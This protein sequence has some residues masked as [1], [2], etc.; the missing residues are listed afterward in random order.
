MK[1]KNLSVFIFMLISLTYALELQVQAQTSRTCCTGSC[2]RRCVK[3]SK[4]L[5]KC[6]K[7]C[8]SKLSRKRITS[9]SKRLRRYVRRNHRRGRNFRS[10]RNS[11]RVVRRFRRH[12][13]RR[14]IRRNP[15][16]RRW[17]RYNKRALRRYSRRINRRQI[18]R[19]LTLRKF[20]RRRQ[21]YLTTYYWPH[22][23]NYY[24]SIQYYPYYH[25][26]WFFYGHYQV[27]Y[28]FY[29]SYFFNYHPTLYYYHGSNLVYLTHGHPIVL[30]KTVLPTII[31]KQQYNVL[32]CAK[33]P[34]FLVKINY[35]GKTFRVFLGDVNDF[36]NLGC[37]YFMDSIVSVGKTNYVNRV[38]KLYNTQK[39]TLKVK[40]KKIIVSPFSKNPFTPSKTSVKRVNKNSSV[41][42]FT[43]N[44]KN[45][46]QNYKKSLLFYHLFNN[47]VHQGKDAKKILK[48]LAKQTKKSTINVLFIA[49]HLEPNSL[50]VLKY[51]LT[52]YRKMT[53]SQLVR[54]TY[55][56]I[57]IF[58]G[59][60]LHHFHRYVVVHNS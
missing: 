22:W 41:L 39:K 8:K 53:I 46:N 5:S 60:M 27:Q 45:S 35:K 47:Q 55:R 28:P 13:P 50:Y 43:L 24:S 58:S 31:V 18:S 52:A 17:S 40:G 19:N 14:V 7:P 9:V 36:T 44:R 48:G 37:L 20:N 33:G 11:R 38:K 6:L 42:R 16:L 32:R 54:I 15:R 2:L 4:S 25:F 10:R 56:R 26:Y 49:D 29:Y 59:I 30:V 12:T 34:K 1:L 23:F 21:Y 3:K 57:R 51:F